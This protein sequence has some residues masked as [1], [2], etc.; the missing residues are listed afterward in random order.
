MCMY[1]LRDRCFFMQKKRFVAD[2][3]RLRSI[4]HDSIGGRDRRLHAII[5]VI[6]VYYH[7]QYKGDRYSYYLQCLGCVLFCYLFIIPESSRITITTLSARSR[8]INTG[9]NESK[10]ERMKRRRRKGRSRKQPTIHI[11]A[12]QFYISKSYEL[13]CIHVQICKM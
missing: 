9:R 1:V 7:I 2:V 8:K 3:I 13:N 11:H 10:N 5:I 6:V 4:W 12:L